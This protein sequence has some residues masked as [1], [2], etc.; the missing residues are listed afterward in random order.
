MTRAGLGSFLDYLNVW[1]FTCMYVHHVN[2]CWPQSSD[3]D[4][5]FPGTGVGVVASHH[6]SLETNLWVPQE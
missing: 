3:E 6:V 2:A 4:V 1:A 5:R